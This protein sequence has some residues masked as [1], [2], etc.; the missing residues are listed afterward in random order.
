[1][2]KYPKCW[3]TRIASWRAGLI[4]PVR[5]SSSSFSS[6]SLLGARFGHPSRLSYTTLT[7]PPLASEHTEFIKTPAPQQTAYIHSLLEGLSNPDAE[8][9]FTN[10][11]HLL[12][13][14]QGTFS[15]SLS[16]EHHLHLILLNCTLLRSASAL[17]V[18]WTAV[19]ATGRRWEAVSGIPDHEGGWSGQDQGGRDAE[20]YTQMERQ[21]LL[22]EINGELA[23]LLAVLYFMV[24]CFRGEEKWGEELSESRVCAEEREGAGR[25]RAELTP[26]LELARSGPRPAHA[27]LLVQP[28]RR[29][30]R[31]QRQRL[32]RQK[33]ETKLALG[34]L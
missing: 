13:I 14:A 18:L 5:P 21:E 17:D 33:G 30:A 12:Y 26:P 31:T 1:M 27:H 25:G 23:L 22:D 6:F 19:K 4:P 34:F 10:A 16:P 2:S 24:E 15:S 29:F 9:R 8:L 32:P 11:R 28:R 7:T 20:G 3:I